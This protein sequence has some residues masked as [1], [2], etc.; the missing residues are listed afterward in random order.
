MAF[1]KLFNNKS[2]WVTVCLVAL[3]VVFGC[4]SKTPENNAIVGSSSETEHVVDRGPGAPSASNPAAP[5]TINSL[6]T[7]SKCETDPNLKSN[8][9]CQIVLTGFSGELTTL[10]NP[11]KVEGYLKND[12]FLDGKLK[13][14]TW[15]A[16]KNSTQPVMITD[17]KYNPDGT[18][19]TIDT[20][21]D[22]SNPNDGTMDLKSSLVNSP[23][24]NVVNGK[25]TVVMFTS[26]PSNAV[27]GKNVT[28]SYPYNAP[29]TLPAGWVSGSPTAEIKI[30]EELTTATSSTLTMPNVLTYE[31]NFLNSDK[32]PI[33]SR[34][35]RVENPWNGQ[36]MFE[37]FESVETFQYDSN[38]KTLQG[39]V[40]NLYDCTTTSNKSC[41]GTS[42]YFEIASGLK[43]YGQFATTWKYTD[44]K[45]SHGDTV[46]QGD[47]LNPNGKNA[48]ILN[49]PNPYHWQCD[50]GY[51][52][53][54]QKVIAKF[55]DIF[56][57]I[58]LSETDKVQSL[59]CDDFGVGL[60]GG[61]FTFDEWSYLWQATG[62]S[63]P[64]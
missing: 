19:Q 45:L 14:T 24:P 51:D 35:V 42:S 23:L 30:T 58:G 63:E 5:A 21:A 18:I 25:Q 37:K 10:N 29:T 60:M 2:L 15:Y 11:I 4:A 26:L 59:T 33:E 61:S 40:K 49:Q 7:P 34:I 48:G 53:A 12:Y 31:V 39:S 64:Q 38:T 36:G 13:S 54:N 56:K 46:V 27:L 57:F 52:T 43:P 1:S 16:S 47:V 17:F 9:L 41:M 62:Q 22:T 6:P 44:G 3:L 55:P 28:F 32:V 20:T 50:I 8:P